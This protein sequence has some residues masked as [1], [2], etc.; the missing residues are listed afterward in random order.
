MTLGTLQSAARVRPPQYFP[1][2]SSQALIPGQYRTWLWEKK[3]EET[4]DGGK[5]GT[6]LRL[7][8]A[9]PVNCDLSLLHSLHLGA[10][11]PVD[12]KELQIDIRQRWK[13]QKSSENFQISRELLA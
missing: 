13:A 5:I 3:V 1:C 6:H 7:H 12:F 8:V 2:P 9:T 11:I 10:L 4:A